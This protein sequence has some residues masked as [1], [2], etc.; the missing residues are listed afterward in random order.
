VTVVA[1][2]LAGLAVGSLAASVWLLMDRYPDAHRTLGYIRPAT[3]TALPMLAACL[4]Y[5]ALT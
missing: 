2:V 5:L 3:L 1:V 4:V